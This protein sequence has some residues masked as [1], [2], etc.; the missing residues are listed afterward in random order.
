MNQDKQTDQAQDIS[1][2]DLDAV[3]GGTGG[4]RRVLPVRFMKRLDQTTPLASADP[5]NDSDP[6]IQAGS[7]DSET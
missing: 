5:G 1:D 4:H 7:T 6:V 2:E 3:A